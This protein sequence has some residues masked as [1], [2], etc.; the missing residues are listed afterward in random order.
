MTEINQNRIKTAKI[1]K[2]TVEFK[3]GQLSPGN[4]QTL[5]EKTGESKT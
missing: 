3:V 2:R 4:D 1:E 5:F